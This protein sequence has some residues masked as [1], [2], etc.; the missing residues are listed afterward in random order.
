[1]DLCLFLTWLFS[2]LNWKQRC[3]VSDTVNIENTKLEITL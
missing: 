3:D 2:L 1:M